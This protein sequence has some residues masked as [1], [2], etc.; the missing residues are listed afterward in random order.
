MENS[1]IV[2]IQ[3]NAYFVVDSFSFFTSVVTAYDPVTANQTL[4]SSW[5][6]STTTQIQPSLE[7][8]QTNTEIQLEPLMTETTPNRI[9]LRM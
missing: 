2:R 9:R 1:A 5:E 8:I 3:E 6:T 7:N 4:L